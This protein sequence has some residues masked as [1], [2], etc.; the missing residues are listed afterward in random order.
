MILALVLCL[1]LLFQGL[2]A[3]SSQ[4][5]PLDPVAALVYDANPLTNLY[6]K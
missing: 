4:K 3:C 1:D 6:A 2:L 5:E